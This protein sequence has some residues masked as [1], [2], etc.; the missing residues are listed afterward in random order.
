MRLGSALVRAGRL[1][2]G[3]A[4]GARNGRLGR[5][6]HDGETPTPLTFECDADNSTALRFPLPKP[7]QPGETATVEIG[8]CLHLP[9]KQG[10]WGYWKDVTFVTNA[11]TL[12]AYCDDA[13][14]HPTPFV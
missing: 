6:R 11:L 7:L 12:L 4:A 14:W 9:N 2:P 1:S 13:G 3:G 8:F 10:R 5:L